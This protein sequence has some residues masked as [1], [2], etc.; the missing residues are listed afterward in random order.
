MRLDYWLNDYWLLYLPWETRAFFLF[1]QIDLA[2]SEQRF[3][4]CTLHLTL[5]FIIQPL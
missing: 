5:T 2:E 4:P 1:W 3:Q